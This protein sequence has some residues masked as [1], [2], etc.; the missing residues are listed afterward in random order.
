MAGEKARELPYQVTHRL[1]K[2]VTFSDLGNTVVIGSVPACLVTEVKSVKIA[3]FNSGSTATLSVG[4][5]Y[6][7]ATA[8]STAALVATANLLAAV[9]QGPTTHAFVDN[10][11]AKIDVAS[12]I[13]ATLAQTGTAGTAGDAYVIVDYQPL[14]HAG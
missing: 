8:S 2:R 5:D 7:D 9:A 12:D 3:D 13:T 14:N 11:L 1:V 10:A 6:S 4:I